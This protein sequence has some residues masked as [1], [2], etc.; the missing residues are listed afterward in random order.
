MRC[1]ALIT[2]LLYARFA[3]RGCLRLGGR[4]AG[5]RSTEQVQDYAFSNLDRFETSSLVTRMTTDVTVLQNAINGGLRPL[6]RGPV[7]LVHGRW[8]CPSAM[9]ARLALVFVVCA[10]VLAAHSLLLIVRKVG[11]HV[12]PAPEGGGPA[13]TMCVQEGLTGIRAVKAFVRGEYEEEKF[14]DVNQE[15]MRHQPAQPSTIAVLNLP[16]FQLVMYTAV[17]LILWFGGDMILDGRPAG[18]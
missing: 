9:N 7:M 11:P 3:A 5:G 4:Y 16:A 6:V 15:L 13:R 2:G 1:L 8:G 14:Q 10:P 12:Q 18:G 17:V